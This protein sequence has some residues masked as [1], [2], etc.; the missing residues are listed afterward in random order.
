MKVDCFLEFFEVVELGMVRI[1]RANM[2]NDLLAFEV[3][4]LA[5]VALIVHD[6]IRHMEPF[7]LSLRMPEVSMLPL[8]DL[9]KLQ[10]RAMR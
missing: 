6:R 10:R 7:Q 1:G 8:L 4:S 3:S 9:N 5:F 2:R